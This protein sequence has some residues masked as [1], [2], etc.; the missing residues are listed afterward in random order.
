MRR[1]VQGE[2]APTFDVEGN[3]FGLVLADTILA[4]LGELAQQLYGISWAGSD[5]QGARDRLLE[6]TKQAGM[7]PRDLQAVTPPAIPWLPARELKPI[8]SPAPVG[9]V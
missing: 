8:L 9:N 3:I 5:F 7:V 4:A 1:R 2:S 6:E